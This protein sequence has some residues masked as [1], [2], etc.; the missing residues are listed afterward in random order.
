MMTTRDGATAM[1]TDWTTEEPT[2]IG[3]GQTV[4]RWNHPTGAIVDDNTRNDGGMTDLTPAQLAESAWVGHRPDGAWEQFP[5]FDDAAT[6][7]LSS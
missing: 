7:A 1:S 5:T 3:P 6:F 4:T 2:E